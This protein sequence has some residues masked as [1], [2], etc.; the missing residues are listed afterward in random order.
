[1]T[2]VAPA[3]PDVVWDRWTAI[4]DWPEW[5]PH[6]AAAAV[7]GPLAPGTGLDLRLRDAKGRDFYT[8]PGLTEVERPSRITWVARGLGVRARTTTMLSPEPDG[9]RVTIETDVAGPLAFTYRIALSDGV[10]ALMYVAM[11]D[12]LTDLV[13]V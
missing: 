13:R 6:C 9:T 2:V 4:A 8:R 7:D 5:N 10:Q 12:A 3:P 11:L 1:M